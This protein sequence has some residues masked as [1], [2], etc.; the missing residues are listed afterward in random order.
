[1]RVRGFTLRQLEQWSSRCVRA[2]PQPAATPQRRF[3]QLTHPA[4]DAVSG[5]RR[6]QGDEAAPVAPELLSR[7]RRAGRVNIAGV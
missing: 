6:S 4:A 7:R 1:M 5:L 3:D 2:P